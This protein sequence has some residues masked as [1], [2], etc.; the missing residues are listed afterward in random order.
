MVRKNSDPE[1]VC[2]STKDFMMLVSAATRVY[3]DGTSEKPAIAISIHHLPENVWLARSDDL[4]GLIVETDTRDEAI[5]LARDMALDLIEL[6]G[7]RPDRK[8][9]KFAFVFPNK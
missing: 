2:L 3:G 8:H 4:P 5:D 6:Q 1:Y 9:Q 7:G